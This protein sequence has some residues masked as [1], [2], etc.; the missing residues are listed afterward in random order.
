[1]QSARAAKTRA[2]ATAKKKTK[3]A[4]AARTKAKAKEK[5]V[6]KLED[7]Q[8][9]KGSVISEEELNV[10]P[11]SVKEATKEKE[12]LF[13]PN[14]GPQTDF[15]AASEDLVFFGGARG[16]GKSYALIVDPMRYF[17]LPNF[18]GLLIRRTMQELRDLINHSL[19]MY[20]KAFPGAKYHKQDK[21]WTFP[22]GAQFVFGYCDGDADW[23]RYQGQQYHWM[24]IDELPQFD[25]PQIIYDLIGSNR[26]SAADLANGYP[27][28]MRFTGNPGNIGSGWVKDMFID[29]A[30]WGEAFEIDVDIPDM[31]FEEGESI[32]CRF[33]PSTIF[34][35]PYLAGNKKYI[36]SLGIQGETRRKQWLEGDW[37]VFD[38]SSFP[39]FDRKVHVVEPFK[40]PASWNRF[41][42]MDWGYASPAC[43]LWFAVDNEG[44]IIVYREMY[45]TRLL[46]DEW[47]ELIFNAEI[48]ENVKYGVLDSSVWA[49]RGDVGPTPVETMMRH[50][51]RWRPSDRSGGSRRA[52][53]VEIHK[54]LF[55]KDD[56]CGNKKPGVVIFKNCLNLI[57][58]LPKLP[59]D[60]NDPEDVDTHAEDHA[61]DAFRYGCMSR[62]KKAPAADNWLTK[63]PQ[64]NRRT[65][66]DRNF[67]Y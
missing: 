58:T 4:Q 41:R 43:C 8:L 26:A 31:D 3:Q 47:A 59:I 54:R 40:I 5:V 19:R 25:S 17:H 63:L 37:D 52:G 62:P 42:A 23:L 22:S 60:K 16:G 13:K 7:A 39:D 45:H 57:R 2:N 61:Y 38:A 33:I 36:A 30:P 24:G 66:V 6:K 9:G 14:I 35:N 18:N 11:E 55:V 64:T 67:G 15:L 29:P 44:D 32:S 20:P 50:G 53:K 56:G 48:G 49:K 28:M 12:Y 34:D 51:V 46:A 1:M 21:V 10:L 65:V 27:Q